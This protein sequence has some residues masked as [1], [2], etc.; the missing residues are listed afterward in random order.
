VGAVVVGA[1]GVI[2]LGLFRGCLATRHGSGKIQPLGNSRPLTAA[3]AAACLAC[4]CGWR[5]PTVCLSNVCLAA[6]GTV[7]DGALQGVYLMMDV[8]SV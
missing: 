5:P 1:Q 4:C 2:L 8:R 3:A 7:V 6:V